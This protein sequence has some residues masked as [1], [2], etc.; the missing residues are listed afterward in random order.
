M[1]LAASEAVGNAARLLRVMKGA[2]SVVL[3]QYRLKSK[4]Y[5]PHE[6]MPPAPY[7]L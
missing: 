1:L 5:I 2:W 4:P 6:P 7:M 3:T